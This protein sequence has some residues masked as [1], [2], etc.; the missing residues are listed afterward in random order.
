MKKN[1][2]SRT[3][4]LEWKNLHQQCWDVGVTMCALGGGGAAE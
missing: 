1:N 2:I 3:E 4:N